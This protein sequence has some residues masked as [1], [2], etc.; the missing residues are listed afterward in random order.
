MEFPRLVYRSASVHK[1]VDCAASFK[2]A[3]EDGWFASV[4]EALAGPVP[5]APEPVDDSPPTRDEMEQ[6]AHALG[7]KFDGRTSDKKLVAM[8]EE[9]LK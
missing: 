5:K 1:C 8:I 6:K 2:S 9:A 7:L 4:P 3:I